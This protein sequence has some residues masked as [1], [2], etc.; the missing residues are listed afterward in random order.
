MSACGGDGARLLADVGG[1]NA[2]FAWQAGPGTPID[3]AR[4]YRCAEHASLQD[5]IATYLR[6]SGL[7]APAQAAIGIANP[8]LGDAVR[9]TNHHWSF[10]TE[11]LRRAL[12][13][14]R[15]LVLNDFTALA[16]AVP[17]LHPDEK[18][19]LCGG[20]AASDAA[21][22]VIGP[23]TGLGVSGL[24]PNGAG[25]WNALRGEGGH[26]TL[27][28]ATAR[29]R[30]V[31]DRL[32][33][34]FGHASAER[35][36][37]GPGLVWMYEALCALDGACVPAGIDVDAAWVANAALQRIDARADE[38]LEL[39]FA[40]LGSMAGNLALTLGAR[41]GVYL[42]GGVLPRV[43]ERLEASRFRERFVGKGRFRAY[44]EDIPVFLIEARES[45]ALR[46]VAAALACCTAV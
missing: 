31:L 38:A 30:A 41:G 44:L 10:S 5:A 46:G 36:V 21:I 15:L 12:G 35:A 25:G 17:T 33:Q 24:I 8:V 42:G 7:A 22:A 29:E 6:D 37:S 23:G 9:M 14:Q 43:I 27:A 3:A 26:A 39:L 18:R 13:L 11:Q 34:R 2:R 4:S 40:F 19:R 32:Q 28:G 1:T 20:A 45:P 16:M